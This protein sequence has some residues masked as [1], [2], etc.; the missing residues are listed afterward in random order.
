MFVESL[1]VLLGVFE[2]PLCAVFPCICLRSSF[3][4]AKCVFG[5]PLMCLSLDLKYILV[6]PPFNGFVED[7]LEYVSGICLEY[8]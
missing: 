2:A 6:E 1:F 5:A 4:K 7:L 3:I 8:V